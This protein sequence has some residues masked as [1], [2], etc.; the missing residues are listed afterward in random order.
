[1]KLS[2]LKYL[3][4]VILL[5]WG[6]AN[7]QFGVS[8]HTMTV[9]VQEI[10]GIQVNIGSI[11][12]AISGADAVA[13]QDDMTTIDQ[14]S[15]LLWGINGNT[16]KITVQTALATPTFTL[17]VLALTPTQGTA[18]P[19]VTLNTTAQDFLL[20]VGRSSG[21]CILKYTGVAFASQGTGTDAHTITFTVQAQ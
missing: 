4:C 17:K 12:M 11:N 18:A 15:T 3:L 13:G 16:K 14:S 1:M 6:R 9:Q 19:E 21:N 2:P 5:L 7:G 8:S 10:T 20:S